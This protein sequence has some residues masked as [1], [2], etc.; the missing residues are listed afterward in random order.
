MDATSATTVRGTQALSEVRAPM[1]G[2]GAR[3]VLERAVLT[4][5]S[6]AFLRSALAAATIKP[7]AF[8]DHVCAGALA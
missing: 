1:I 4:N 3:E 5:I 2:P 6:R 8:D 7:T